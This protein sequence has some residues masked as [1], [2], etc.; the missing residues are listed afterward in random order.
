MIKRYFSTPFFCLCL[1][2]SLL[3]LSNGYRDNR[4]NQE[5]VDN[6]SRDNRP[7]S[8]PGIS[9]DSQQQNPPQRQ[10]TRKE[11]LAQLDERDQDIDSR[12]YRRGSWDYKQNWRY[13]REAFY[14]GDTQPKAYRDEHPEGRGG[15]GYEP[16][17]NYQHNSYNRR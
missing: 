2:G 6:Q 10:L 13:D 1:A 12:A 4:Y 14:R 15:I 5:N 16:D 3:S 9:D 11:K 7:P 17:Y 8:R